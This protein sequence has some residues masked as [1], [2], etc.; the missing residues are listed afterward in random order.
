MVVGVTRRRRLQ[1]AVVAGLAILLAGYAFLAIFVQPV[2]AGS[3]ATLIGLPGQDTLFLPPTQPALNE[4]P[5]A[6]VLGYVD[7]GV[8]TLVQS[9]AN[10]GPIPIRI[11]GVET[12]HLPGWAGLVTIQGARPA[13]NFG[14][15]PCCQLDQAA[16]WS[17]RRFLPI[18]VNPGQQGAIAVRLLLSH[19]EDNG[20]GMYAIIDSIK[21]D[22]TIL[23]FPHVA[24]VA[25]GPYWFASPATCPRSGPARPA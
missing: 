16:T 18:T 22:Y 2:A 10:T 6:L 14:Q 8:D 21:V 25:V 24:R 17:A 12:D 5:P 20:P 4:H 15:P 7:Y 19:C 1:L 23:G 3:D 11:T 9:L 13:V